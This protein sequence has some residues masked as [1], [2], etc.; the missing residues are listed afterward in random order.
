MTGDGKITE[1]SADEIR[2]ALASRTAQDL[3]VPPQWREAA[4]LVPLQWK[5]GRWHVLLTRRTRQVESHKGEIS[6]PGGGRDATDPDLLYTALREADEEV[7][8]NPAEVKVLG[9]LDDIY[10]ISNYRIR[11]YVGRIPHPFTP[12]VQPAE[13]DELICLP[14]ADFLD[15]ACFAETVISRGGAPYSIY[16]FR[17]AGHTVWGATGKILKQYLEVC[18]GFAPSGRPGTDALSAMAE[19]LRQLPGVREVK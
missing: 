13:I 18:L 7:G 12:V 10:T 19:T 4:V 5:D 11:P 15:P 14:L 16:F 6:F 1:P 9:R 17:V 8:L 2:S 3:P